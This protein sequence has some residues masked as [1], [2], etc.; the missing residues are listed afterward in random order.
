MKNIAALL[1]FIPISAFTAFAQS[2]GWT[3]YIRSHEPVFPC[4]LI[5]IENEQIQLS[6]DSLKMNVAIDSVQMLAREKETHF[7][8]GAGY[9]ALA[10]VVVGAAVG[11]VMY[12]KPKPSGYFT[13]DLGPAVSAVGGGV[14]GVVTGFLV[15]GIIGTLSCGTEMY[16]LSKETTASRMHLIRALIYR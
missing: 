7:W 8:A 5:G 13:L 10:G 14:L 3:V 4:T 16:D 11:L 9:G 6:C 12:E 1:V 15:G 2:S